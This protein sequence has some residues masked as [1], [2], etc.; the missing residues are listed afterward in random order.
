MLQYYTKL[1]SQQVIKFHLKYFEN[2]LFIL[3][4]YN[5]YGRAN[6]GIGVII[7][8]YNKLRP[9]IRVIWQRTHKMK[10]KTKTT[11]GNEKKTPS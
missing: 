8:W 7:F 10:K 2:F 3:N 5:D 11:K 1:I 9:V 6:I 4:F